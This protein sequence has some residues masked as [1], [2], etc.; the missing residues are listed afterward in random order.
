VAPTLVGPRLVD[1]G[2]VVAHTAVLLS[3]NWTAAHIFLDGRDGLL[4]PVVC[5]VHPNQ[6]AARYTILTGVIVGLFAA[7]MSIGR[8][9]RPKNI[10]RCLR[11]CGV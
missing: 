5:K 10:G 6:E 7:V 1:F 4:P 3:F 9:G 2:S 8:D 11:L